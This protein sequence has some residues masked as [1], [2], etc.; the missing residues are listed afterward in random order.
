[1][2]SQPCVGFAVVVSKSLLQRLKAI[3]AFLLKFAFSAQ[4]F[5]NLL[6]RYP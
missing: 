2:Q 3:Q 6:S 4:A 5:S 1:M